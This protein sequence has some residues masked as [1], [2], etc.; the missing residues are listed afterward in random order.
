MFSYLAEVFG[1]EAGVVDELNKNGV[2]AAQ[3]SAEVDSVLWCWRQSSEKQIVVEVA[4][5]ITIQGQLGCRPACMQGL[6][7]EAQRTLK[8]GH[9]RAHPHT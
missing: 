7:L 6:V 5:I 1:F 4:Q 3:T 9:I 8:R 2:A